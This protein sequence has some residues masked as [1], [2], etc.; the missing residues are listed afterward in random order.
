MKSGP[1]LL[2]CTAFL[3]MALPIRA[4]SL[5]YTGAANAF[6][7]AESSAPQFRASATKMLSP[8][9]PTVIS[10]PLSAVAPLWGHEIEYP[11][12]PAKLSN[13]ALSATMFDT[14]ARRLPAP[15]IDGQLSDPTPVIASTDGFEPSSSFAPWA[16]EP[17]F[18]VDTVFPPSLGTS[19]QS[20]TFTELASDDP[21]LSVFAAEGARHKIERE[22][23][24]RD[25]GKNQNQ[26]ASPSV[27]VSEPKAL[28]LLLFGLVA[29][30]ILAR[31]SNVSPAA[32]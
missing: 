5:S 16:S 9:T 12:L 26:N 13:T 11:V 22:R 4:D 6:T 19:L 27:E 23:E 25:N 31:R 30:A 2:L 7:D 3:I 20:S 32:V 18:V 1:A 29:V 8:V 14:S 10:D 21:A 24:K 28:P 17:S 15:Q